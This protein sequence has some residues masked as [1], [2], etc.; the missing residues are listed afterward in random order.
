MLAEVDGSLLQNVDRVL[1]TSNASVAPVAQKF[2][3][4]AAFVAM[5]NNKGRSTA[6]L[7][8]KNFSIA[9]TDGAFS[10]LALVHPHVVVDA[11]TKHPL[12]IKP[13]R[14]KRIPRSPYSLIFCGSSASMF[15]LEPVEVIRP[16]WVCIIMPTRCVLFGWLLSCKLDELPEVVPFRNSTSSSANLPP[17]CLV[18][19]VLAPLAVAKRRYRVSMSKIMSVMR[20]TIPASDDRPIA[21]IK[22]AM[23]WSLPPG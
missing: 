18:K 14:S 13:F 17:P 21:I 20:F 3:D 22:L 8:T 4:I 15:A 1:K 2:T 5:V 19:R 23:Q 10:G 11:N 16:P 9:P 12:E 7:A 6:A